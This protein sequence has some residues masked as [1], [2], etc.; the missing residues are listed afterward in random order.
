[1]SRRVNVLGLLAGI[2]P[3]EGVGLLHRRAA[4][5]TAGVLAK[6]ID[7]QD[8]AAG[9][10]CEQGPRLAHHRVFGAAVLVAKSRNLVLRVNNDQAGA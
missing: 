8:G 3:I 6:M 2:E 5:I 7:N 4:L 10:F 9:H 1:M